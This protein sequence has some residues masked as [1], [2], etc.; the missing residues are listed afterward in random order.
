M[1]RINTCAIVLL[2]MGNLFAQWPYP[3]PATTGFLIA[4]D[5]LSTDTMYLY[6]VGAKAYFTEGNSWGTQASMGDTGLKVFVNKYINENLTGEDS[7]WDGR[8]YLI[9]DFSLYKNQ[10]KNLFIDSE[11]EM[12]V[13]HGSQGVY[14]WHFQIKDNGNGTFK[15]YAAD[16]SKYSHANYPGTYIGVVEYADGTVANTVSPLLNPDE[17]GN[18]RYAAY[19][20]D[21]AFVSKADYEAHQKKLKAYRASQELLAA[22]EKAKAL[23]IDVA[24]E[25]AVYDNTGSSIETMN[26][27]VVSLKEKTALYYETAI[28][29]SSPMSMDEEYVINTTFDTDHDGWT[30]TTGCQNNLIASNQCSV[31]GSDGNFYFTTAFWEN[32]NPSGFTGKMYRQMEYMPKGV[33]RLELS[34]FANGG[35]GTYIYMND[36]SV[37]VVSGGRPEKYEVMS[38]NDSGTVEIGLKEVIG[39]SNWVGI[40]NCHLTYYGNNK[41]AYAYLIDWAIASFSTDAQF[42]SRLR[43]EYEAIMKDYAH[44]ET[45]EEAKNHD[46]ILKAKQKEIADCIKAYKELRIMVDD[47]KQAIEDGFD[48]EDFGKSAVDLALEADEI[49][50]EGGYTADEAISTLGEIRNLIRVYKTDLSTPNN[51][52]SPIPVERYKLSGQRV[53]AT[54]PS[55]GIHIIRYSDGTTKKV[56]SR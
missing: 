14:C 45:L 10:W 1:K 7:V 12:Y 42:Y 52:D 53:N 54:T 34:A 43:E 40:D 38:V 16:D 25:Q 21:W 23:G 39:Y 11:T 50:K 56:Y 5:A 55:K 37:E 9:Y 20:T 33:Y 22:L 48:F 15:I 3:E 17:M 41:E 49:M 13:D 24:A 36:D 28:T 19:H 44:P 46:Q 32:W 26:G 18:T 2:L 6:N 27:A 31:A 30:S 47:I 35:L 8:T 51:S 4:E 29:P